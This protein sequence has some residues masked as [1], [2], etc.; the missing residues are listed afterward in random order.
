LELPIGS[1]FMSKI[2]SYFK[3]IRPVNVL[4]AG[5]SV[6]VG[7]VVAGGSDCYWK[8]ILAFVSAGLIAGGGNAINDYFDLEI[9]RINKPRRPLTKGEILP[10]NAMLVSFLLLTSGIILSVFVNA[11]ALALCVLASLLLV[12]YSRFLKRTLLIGNLT[13][14]LASSLAFVYGGIITKDFRLSLVPAVL[15]FFF[16]LGREILK[17]LEDFRGDVAFGAK[18]LPVVKG[19]RISKIFISVVFILLVILIF[20]PYI[21]HLFSIIYLIVAFL[22]VILIL[23]YATYSLWKDSSTRNLSRLSILLK[24]SM[25]FGLVAL[26]LG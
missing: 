5:F 15:S 20:L 3:L 9:D 14:S 1:D 24:V 22:G 25:C 7:T 2:Y 19:E 10:K 6:V 17:D 26:L 18:T 8:I 16:H 4:I 13:V 23:L 21:L 12:I 11:V